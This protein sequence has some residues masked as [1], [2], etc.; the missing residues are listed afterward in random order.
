MVRLGVFDVCGKIEDP[1]FLSTA[2]LLGVRLRLSGGLDT[3]ANS[4]AVCRLRL[5]K[6]YRNESLGQEFFVAYFLL[7]LSPLTT[8]FPDFEA[9]SV[10]SF[11]HFQTRYLPKLKLPD[12]CMLMCIMTWLR[13]HTKQGDQHWHSVTL[14]YMSVSKALAHRLPVS[15]SHVKSLEAKEIS[16]LMEVFLY[17]IP[18]NVDAF[19]RLL[20][21]SEGEQRGGFI[22]DCALGNWDQ[23]KESYFTVDDAIHRA[24]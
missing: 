14:F 21:T 24:L 7:V 3:V 12:L 8:N 2:A 19:A 20:N 22:L 13:R 6:A 23:V 10:S 9:F 16:P 4:G 17:K 15:R 1:E 11:E 18:L 5:E